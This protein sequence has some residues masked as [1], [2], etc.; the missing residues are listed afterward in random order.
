MSLSMDWDAGDLPEI[1]E[2]Y[3]SCGHLGCM[4]ELPSDQWSL[5]I[6]APRYKKGKGQET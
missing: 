2:P 3:L 5:Q 6:H 1:L 4:I